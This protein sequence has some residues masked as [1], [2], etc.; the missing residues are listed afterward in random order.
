MRSKRCYFTKIELTKPSGK[1]HAPTDRTIDRIDNGLGYVKGNV[2]AM[3][4]GVNSF[5]G[6]LENPAI[7]GINITDMPKLIEKFA[8]EIQKR[9]L[10]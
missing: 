7:A 2:V 1:D 8:K 4:K 6:I 9:K 5:K 3:A 10:K